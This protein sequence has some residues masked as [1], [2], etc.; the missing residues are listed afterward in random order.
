VR[1]H[2]A[3]YCV[4]A[5]KDG[6]ICFAHATHKPRRTKGSRPPRIDEDGIWQWFDQTDEEVRSFTDWGKGVHHTAVVTRLNVKRIVRQQ[7]EPRLDRVEQQI[8]TLS[9]Q[10]NRV[11]SKI[12]RLLRE[13]GE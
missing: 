4:R 1:S 11:E 6:T 2:K 10:M 3:Y 7:I 5:T 12:D 8:M 13:E 9:E